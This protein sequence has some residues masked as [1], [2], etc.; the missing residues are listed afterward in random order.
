[1]Y[2]Y[3]LK[4]VPFKGC[5]L[6]LQLC[7][8]LSPSSPHV[9]GP[10]ALRTVALRALLAWSRLKPMETMV[11][12]CS[13]DRLSVGVVPGAELQPGSTS[14]AEKSADRGTAMMDTSSGERHTEADG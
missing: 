14:G 4:K 8:A 13:S 9:D 1:M 12:R 10:G 5:S 3:N 2:W 6:T 11:A 7:M